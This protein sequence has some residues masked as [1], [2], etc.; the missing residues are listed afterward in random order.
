LS[1]ISSGIEA[2]LRRRHK[3]PEDFPLPITA[4]GYTFQLNDVSD[5]VSATPDRQPVDYH[6]LAT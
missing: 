5:V 6:P 3:L 4:L 2:K 1:G